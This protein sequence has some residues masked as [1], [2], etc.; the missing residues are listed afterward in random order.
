MEFARRDL[1]IVCAS[2]SGATP[3]YAANARRLVLGPGSDPDELSEELGAGG[4][5]NRANS[6]RRWSTDIQ[7]RARVA[8][9][10]HFRPDRN[11]SSVIGTLRDPSSIAS[12]TDTAGTMRVAFFC[13]GEEPR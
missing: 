1:T 13:F 2:R 4:V 11:E 5:H 6:H 8:V 3:T 10:S 12:T 9:K 7:T